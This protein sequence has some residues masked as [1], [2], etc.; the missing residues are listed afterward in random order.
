MQPARIMEILD[1]VEKAAIASA[2]WNGKGDKVAVDQAATTAMREALNAIDF[3]GRI[4]IGEGE[5]DEAPMLYIGEEVGRGGEEID[6]A[7]DPLEGTNL[8]AFNKPNALTTIAIAPR[9]ALLFAPDTYLQKIAAGPAAA[10][11]VHIDKTPAENVAAVAEALGKPVGEVSV[12]ILDRDRH[13]DLVQAVRDAG[14]RVRLIGDGDVFGAIATAVPGTGIDLYMGAGGAPEGV[15]AAVGLKAIGGVF[16]GRLRFD[17]DRDGE[18]K[19]CR[20]EQTADVDLDG[21]LTMDMLVR[22]DDAAFLACGVTDGEM[23]SGVSKA[24]GCVT[25]ESIIMNA[26][27]QT[28]RFI[29]TCR[30]GENGS[31]RFD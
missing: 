14:A 25:T 20:A 17:L 19:R 23:V 16:M 21:V 29:K 6:I 3:A 15:L 7:V 8:C 10:G 4:V 28:V 1:V 2:E 30:R 12:C 26:A 11:A 18:E 31:V 24:H 9:G 13:K 5:R 27:D 22:T